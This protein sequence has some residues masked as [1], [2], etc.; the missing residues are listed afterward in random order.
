MTARPDTRWTTG[1]PFVPSGR[2]LHERYAQLAA[3]APDAVAI[4]SAATTVSYGELDRT[5]NAWAAEL[6]AAGAGPA[7]VVPVVAPHGITLVTALLAVLKTGASYALLDPAWPRSRRQDVIA[8]LD[9][10]VVV[11]SP[12]TGGAASARGWTP[13]VTPSPA[14]DG[15]RPISVA[16]TDPCSVFF[17]SGTT[18][19][20]KGVL[21]THDATA[22]LFHQDTFAR[23]GPRT[24]IPLAAPVPW[25]AFSL[26]LWAA[27]LTGGSCLIIDEPYLS[28]HSLRSGVAG[29]G[30]DTVWLTSSLFNMV[31]DED[32]AAFAGVDQVMVGGERL[33][34][35]HVR[36][37]LRHHRDIALINGYGPVESTVFATTHR[38]T[39]ADCDREGGIPVGRP[40]PGTAVHV[41][42]ADRPC[43][44]GEIGEICVSG[45]GLAIGYLGDRELTA[46]KFVTIDVD[47]RPVR[48]YRT[49]D[50]GVLDGTGLLHFRGRADRQLKIRGHRVEPSEV[51]RQIELLLP[52]V[53]AC[54]VLARR[55]DAGT[56]TELIA[57]CVP[58]EPGDS[59]DGAQAVLRAGLV[60]YQRPA[61]VVSVDAFPV[62]ARGKLDEPA[63]LARTPGPTGPARSGELP[64]DPLTVAVAEVV[65]AVLGRHVPA[66]AGFA[67]LGGS[68]L[69]AGRVCARLTTRLGRPVPV[70][71]LYRNPSVAALARWLRDTAP[72]DSPPGPEPIAGPTPLTPMQRMYLT[73]HLVAENDLTSHCRLVWVIE[74]EL[75]R[76][77]LDAAV[78][79]VHQRHESLRAAY[80][81]DPTPT[82]ELVDVPAPPVETL[83]A[84]PSLE[85]AVAALRTE[86]AAPLAPEHADLWRVLVVPVG[87]DPSVTVLGCVVHHIAFDGASESVLATD[88][89]HA[90]N[91]ALAGTRPPTRPAPPSLGAQHRERLERARHIDIGSRTAEL[92]AELT[93]TPQLRWPAGHTDP[94]GGEPGRVELPIGPATADG[95]DALAAAAGTTRFVVL[96]SL[97]A[98]TVAE[99][100]GQDDFAI[101]VP[102]AQRDG[103][104]LDLAI[105]C[106]IGMLCPRL[107]G[108]ALLDGP[109]AITE[110]ARVVADAMAGQDVPLPDLVAATVQTGG[111]RPPLYQILFALQDNPVPRLDLTGT[112]TTFHRQPYL[113]L[114]LELHAELW[115]DEAGGLRLEIGFLPG[116]VP[117]A[118]AHEVAKRYADRLDATRTDSTTQDSTAT[119]SPAPDST[120]RGDRP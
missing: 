11:E 27:L 114:P 51:E 65:A 32:V 6:A 97:F 85:A 120:A 71:Q 79:S 73:R 83:A 49:G 106:H 108:A 40:V 93:G 60:A 41:L 111:D 82:A 24:V 67:E 81:L 37:F 75:D 28:A 29:H 91:S 42:H 20:P 25:D 23:F 10:P 76:A 66:D 12:A 74:G 30:V 72:G 39:E 80:L 34:V 9:P 70:S 116:R 77:A 117:E 99:V 95:V 104:G 64:G 119:A 36:R 15:F 84:R 48:V 96:L 3:A 54:R 110:T 44:V 89:A 69:A 109:D 22:R 118:T 50:L 13:P 112:R 87:L 107:R 8:Q 86:S 45:H 59:L 46:T 17:T 56:A 35:P 61:V 62:T 4:R 78:E 18:G 33:S 68:S 101:G 90:Y 19:R 63:L 26:E 102:V 38:I 2:G 57:F 47:G 100:T 115:P 55:D 21:T 53:R 52:G 98:R 58:V 7:T 92:A 88:L 5:A 14:G 43:A 94:G 1:A 113:A 105:G 103:A 31:V 16:G